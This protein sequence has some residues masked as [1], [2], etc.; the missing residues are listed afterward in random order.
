[1]TVHLE[2]APVAIVLAICAGIIGLSAGGRTG[3]VIIACILALFAGA[4]AHHADLIT[5]GLLQ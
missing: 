2:Y 5:Q 3:L 1:M 4:A